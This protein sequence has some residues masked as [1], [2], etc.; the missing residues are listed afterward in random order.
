MK[1]F[2]EFESV[3]LGA[4]QQERSDLEGLQGASEAQLSAWIQHLFHQYLGYT[5]WKEITREGSA[6]VGAKGGKQLFPDL[7]I[8]VLD[9]GVIFVECKRPGRLG[10][11]RGQEELD[12]AV[13]QLRAYIRA[14]VDRATV[15]PK[16]VLGVVADGNR[17]F[18]LGLNR[19]NEF[20]TIAEWAFL[21]DDPRL[22]AQRMWLLAK[23]ALAQ[24]TSAVVEFL[25]RRTLAEVLK[26]NTKLLTR[27]VNEKLPDGSVTE[28][29]IGKWLR[30]ALTDTAALPRLVAPEVASVGPAAQAAK[31][32]PETGRA[33]P[34]P[35]ELSSEQL[36][37]GGKRIGLNDLL[38]AGLLLPQD[39][40]MVQGMEGR[41]QTGS[42]TADGKI[43]VAGK[44]FDAVSPA[45][46][47]ALE[48]AGRPRKATNG[49]ATWRV[50]RGGTYIGTLLE[51]RAQY[52]DK[53]QEASVSG[54]PQDGGSP[55]P[56]APDSAVLVAVEELKPLLTLL[57]E[58][59]VKASKATV[60][61]YAGKMV[62]AYAYP[63]KT[64]LPRLR[65]YVGGACPEWAI[66]DN[67]YAYWCY[68][69]NWST[70]Q[71]RVLA[72]LKEAPRRRAE[73]M[74]AGREAYTRRAQSPANL[75]TP[76]GD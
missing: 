2:A 57:P 73:D 35:E 61:L 72:L 67:T 70:N 7:R 69:D 22:I 48:L 28:D 40:L 21:T 26:E 64:G 30:D 68:A 27:K 71:D 18:L 1:S 17:W 36:D 19:V 62:V 49:W 20:H 43:N 58:L 14:H 47:H 52:E 9:N 11:P 65:V 74:T 3:F 4:L 60:S 41:Q 44:V 63:R 31:A 8:D 29:L 32:P 25:A 66:Q 33:G 75:A 23:P 51:I 54:S 55:I 46:L 39:Q 56:D 15:K 45:A 38:S 34:G 50:L 37:Q 59:T 42:I 13:A 16:T 12:D 24:P 6:P 53:E 5:H 10:G 76:A